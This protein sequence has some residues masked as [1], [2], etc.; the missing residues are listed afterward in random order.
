MLRKLLVTA[1]ALSLAGPAAAATFTIGVNSNAA[2]PTNNDFKSQLNGL[3]FDRYAFTGATLNVV[4]AATEAWTIDFSLFGFENAATNTF[5]G[6]T[7]SFTYSGGPVTSSSPLTGGISGV[8]NF[9]LTNLSSLQFTSAGKPSATA[10]VGDAG[11]GLFY[12]SGA[13]TSGLSNIYFGYD[14]NLQVDDNHDD[15]IFRASI[16][17]T[18]AVP[19]PASWAMMIGGMGIV[20]MSLRSRRRKTVAAIA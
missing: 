12:K 16:R 2:I 7:A 5:T 18:G 9:S 6:G 13:A 3:G 17:T 4:A 11:F 14:D 10:R 1:A 15:G 8:G 20:G 19:E